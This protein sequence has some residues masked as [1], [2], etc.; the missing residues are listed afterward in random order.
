MT[1]LRKARKDYSETHSEIRLPNIFLNDCS[2]QCLQRTNKENDLSSSGEKMFRKDKSLYFINRCNRAE[3]ATHVSM[4]V[5]NSPPRGIDEVFDC[6]SCLNLIAGKMASP[7]APSPPPPHSW[8]IS[9]ILLP[10]PWLTH[11]RHWNTWPR[12]PVHRLANRLSHDQIKDDCLG[13][14]IFTLGNG[15]SQ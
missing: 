6:L 8:L 15:A 14:Q 7:A 4:L 1:F 12:P 9:W 2:L 13:S 5:L 11:R 10:D 3:K